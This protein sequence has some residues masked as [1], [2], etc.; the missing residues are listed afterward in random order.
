VYDVH[1]FLLCLTL[2]ASFDI[3]KSHPKKYSRK[4]RTCSRSH[5]SMMIDVMILKFEA[6]LYCVFDFEIP[7]SEENE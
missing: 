4:N 2:M 1:H 3:I 6:L 5:S 7:M